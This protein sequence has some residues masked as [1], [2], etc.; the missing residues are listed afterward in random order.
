M[1]LSAKANA[2]GLVRDTIST[3]C[4]F[5]LSPHDPHS[6]GAVGNRGIGRHCG[7]GQSIGKMKNFS[8]SWAGLQTAQRGGNPPSPESA[9]TIAFLIRNPT[10]KQSLTRPAARGRRSCPAARRLP[11]HAAA[12]EAGR[13]APQSCD[14]SRVR[15]DGW[16]QKAAP[17]SETLQ[18][19]LQK[20]NAHDAKGAAASGSFQRRST[21]AVHRTA[22]ELPLCSRWGSW[23]VSGASPQ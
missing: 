8:A 16:R 9:R 4:W 14:P 19:Q 13:V 2:H 1:L 12:S 23:Y 17:Q 20:R 10:Q 11:S 3:S 21:F 18:P 5:S 15:V 22:L 6:L 7:R